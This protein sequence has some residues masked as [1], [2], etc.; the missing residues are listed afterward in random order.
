MVV[1]VVVVV[2]GGGGGG[3]GG[4]DGREEHMRLKEM[5]HNGNMSTCTT[6]YSHTSHMISIT[7][8]VQSTCGY[9]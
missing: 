7:K 8:I 1:V 2:M 3:G 4:G 6:R 5:L 9:S